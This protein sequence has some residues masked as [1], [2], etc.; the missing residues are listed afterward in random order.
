MGDCLSE[1]LN[2][3]RV[4]LLD[5][6]TG[7]NLFSM[8]LKSGDAP[9]LWNLEYPEKIQKHYQ[10]FINAGSDIVL[11]NSFGANRYRLK[12]H[13]LESKVQE[14]NFEAAR[15]LQ[16]EVQACSRE[17][18]VAGAMGP[19][20][21]IFAP[22]GSLSILDGSVAFE[23]QAIALKEGGVDVLWIETLS[24]VEEC[25]AAVDGASKTG[26]P[27]VLTLSIE[28][29]GRTMMGLTPSDIIKMYSEL[30]TSI[31]AIGTNCGLG[32]AEVIAAIMN[33]KNAA[34]LLNFE[35]IFIAKANCGIPEWKNGE[36][37]YDGSP[38]LMA[39]YSRLAMDAG[40]TIIGGCC[41]TTPT[42]IKA[43]RDAIDKNI[44]KQ[45]PNI[46][47]IESELGVITSGAKA[48]LG[49]DLSIEGGVKGSG[50]RAVRKRRNRR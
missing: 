10:S 50:N 29:N 44:T 21:E 9:E 45:R 14:L 35:P 15:I 39:K 32:A 6:A 49:G 18:V 38:E 20:G 27:I 46:S 2:K 23:E 41:G 31:F 8:G 34:D 33:M 13:K 47:T 4:L 25:H 40:A 26:L 36:I 1:L 30:K 37:C 12:L 17:V 7:T 3:K 24:S 48:Q 11:T 42:H 28:T 5:G 43:M 22:A 16:T 19:T